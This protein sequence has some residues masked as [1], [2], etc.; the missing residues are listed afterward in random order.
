[1]MN[2]KENL[3][4]QIESIL[5]DEDNLNTLKGLFDKVNYLYL[6]S[7]IEAYLKY[8]ISIEHLE[9]IHEIEEQKKMGGF[10]LFSAIKP[11][12]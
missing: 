12:N 8:N 1:M 2:E 10:Y 6:P 3:N 5:F 4:Q 11:K 7:A 9:L